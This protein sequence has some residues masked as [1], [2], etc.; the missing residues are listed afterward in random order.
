MFKVEVLSKLPIMSH[1]MF[2]SLIQFE[3]SDD[4]HDE[5][6]EEEHH[7]HDHSAHETE[8]SGADKPKYRVQSCCVQR[9]PSAIAAKALQ[10]Q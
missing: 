3:V 6:C 8:E 5:N 4:H 7:G 2:G 9:I 10:T 1:F